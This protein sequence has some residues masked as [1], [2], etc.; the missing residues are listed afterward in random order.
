MPAHSRDDIR[1]AVCR[2]IALTLERS[3]RNAP[4]FSDQDKPLKEYDGFDSQCGVEVTLELEQILG[5]ADLGNNI[6]IKGTGKAV[7]ARTIS[8]I[9]DCV[10]RQLQNGSQR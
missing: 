1:K 7:G 3:G 5:V 9:V 2:A 4:A 10:L 8:E 6:F